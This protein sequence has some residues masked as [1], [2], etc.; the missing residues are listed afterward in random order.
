MRFEVDVSGADEGAVGRDTPGLVCVLADRKASAV[1][2]RRPGQLVL[3][4]DSLLELDGVGMGKP[5]SADAARAMWRNL[6][7]NEAILHTGHCL[8]DTA[9]GTTVSALCS[10]RV[11]FGRPTDTELSA[12][13]ASG[14]PLGLAGAFSIEGLAAPFIDGIDGDPSN[15]LGLS[16]PALRSMLRQLDLSITDLW[17]RE[18]AGLEQS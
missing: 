4:C 10:T 1:A 6:S 2:A 5:G 17:H 7:G 14:E 16:M 3:G 9:A 15:V 8:M 18:S 12:Y 13:I 11:R